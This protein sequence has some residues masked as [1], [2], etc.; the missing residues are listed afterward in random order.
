V[1]TTGKLLTNA[2]T[3]K[4]EFPEWGQRGTSPA[5]IGP[6]ARHFRDQLRTPCPLVLASNPKLA[7]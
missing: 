4:V 3:G 6:P 1:A 7:K 2:V 5:E